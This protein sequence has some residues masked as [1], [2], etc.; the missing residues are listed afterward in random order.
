MH[1]LLWRQ[2]VRHVGSAETVHAISPEWRAF[3][4]AVDKAYDE[5]DAD[6]AL[7]DRSLDLTSQELLARNA[8]IRRRNAE[9]RLR[10]V[11]AR[12]AA[13]RALEASEARAQAIVGALGDCLLL[14]DRDGTLLDVHAGDVPDLPARLELIGRRVA[15]ALPEPLASTLSAR[16]ASALA[17][18]Q[19]ESWE[20]ELARDG[21]RR[22]YEAR[23]TMAGAQTV[24]VLLRNVTENARMRERL[25]IADRMASLGT[26]AAGVAHEINN[27]LTYVLGNLH[28]VREEIAAK[29]GAVHDDLED[30]LREAMLG[31][32]RVREIVRELKT[33]SRGDAAP[34]G[35]VDVVATLDA[36][37]A[38]AANEIRHRARLEKHYDPVPRVLGNA[39]RLGQVFLNL[40]I[41]AAQALPVGRAADHVITVA[42]STL[43]DGRAV[44]EI[45]DS[46][47][48]I[49]PEVLPHV[50]DP[51]FTTKPTGEGTGLGLSICHGIV[52]SLGGEIAVETA[53]GQGTCFRIVLPPSP[54]GSVM[55][56]RD[57]PRSDPPQLRRRVLVIDDEALVGRS[58]RRALRGHDV[59]VATSGREGLRL[60]L[61][62]SAFDVVL[63][64][65]MMPDLSGMDLY[66][67]VA[68][69][70]RE[71]ADRFVLMSGG[72]FSDAAKS[73]LERVP[74]AR[75]NK[76]FAVDELRE[77]LLGVAAPTAG[78]S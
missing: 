57:L 48:G 17:T 74:N 69:R 60:V 68:A 66:E 44:V 31:A 5:F 77:L 64:D 33:F 36:S 50:F 8:E 65:L 56:R 18:E 72:A 25:V 22:R 34:L 10:D 23:L 26:L 71:L 27:P 12:R 45:A 20:F 19:P 32:E 47:P 43:A 40:L 61:E 73:F 52:S 70:R 41:N 62:D 6:R 30:A 21:E 15:D 78:A 46:G 67:A 59:V 7:M 2:L 42:T 53:L 51:F 1:K 39:S 76:P 37:L 63:C 28:H 13:E 4:D 24:V 54:P 49:A 9:E 55:P 38:M 35:P 75:I 29:G 14:V 16:L 11:E 58:I 3:V